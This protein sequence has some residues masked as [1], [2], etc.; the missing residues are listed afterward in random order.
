MA[1]AATHPGSVIAGIVQ[2]GAVEGGVEARLI[3]EPGGAPGKDKY[4][5][6]DQLINQTKIAME[7]F[8]AMNRHVAPA[9]DVVMPP[10]RAVVRCVK[11]VEAHLQFDGMRVHL[12]LEVGRRPVRLQLSVQPPEVKHLPRVRCQALLLFD[13]S[14]G[15]AAGATD[16]RSVT[17]MPKGPDW[18]G[19]LPWMRDG[20]YLDPRGPSWPRISYRMQFCEGDVL[21]VDLTVPVGINP[22]GSV[23][24]AAVVSP[25]IIPEQL[26]TVPRRSV[27][28]TFDGLGYMGEI[29]EVNGEHLLI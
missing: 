4:F 23:D 22:N 7:V 25:Q 13:H 26:I 21:P 27:L 15:H 29:I 5:D 19:K 2:R 10:V 9:R 28:Y 14:S 6:N 3:L 11:P 17:A 16:S 18:N 24:P 20:W 12:Q 8:D 1:Y